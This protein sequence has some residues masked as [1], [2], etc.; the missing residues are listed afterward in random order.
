VVHR[1][2]AGRSGG[3]A[4]RRS[5]TARSTPTWFTAVADEFLARV[6]ARRGTGAGAPTSRRPRSC[7]AIELPRALNRS[8][9]RGA[10]DWRSR[11]APVEPGRAAPGGRGM[12][13]LAGPTA[14]HAEAL[15]VV[16]PAPAGAGGASARDHDR[17]AAA[18][19]PHRCWPRARAG[20]Q[21]VLVHPRARAPSLALL[22]GTGASMLGRRFGPPGAPGRLVLLPVNVL[23]PGRGGLRLPAR[24]A[25]SIPARPPSTPRGPPRVEG[26]EGGVLLRSARRRG[27]GPDRG[28]GAAARGSSPR[29][30]PGRPVF[31]SWG[32]RRDQGRGDLAA[33][34]PDQGHRGVHV[35]PTSSAGS[36]SRSPRRPGGEPRFTPNAMTPG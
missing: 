23:A 6:E 18:A 1:R 8:R 10:S 27:A 28:A 25:A 32:R 9:R 16:L 24:D 3:P 5:P 14:R 35:P 36:R 11:R 20:F 17:G 2:G 19:P 30:D 22:E 13:V 7:V 31:R 15:L 12:T 21:R 26:A 34:E 4:R 29:A 33:A